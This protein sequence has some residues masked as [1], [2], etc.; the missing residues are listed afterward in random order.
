MSIRF[1]A[2]AR[3]HRVG[4]AR[5]PAPQHLSRCRRLPGPESIDEE[6]WDERVAREVRH[7]ELIEAS[8]DRAEAHARLGDFEHALDWLDRVAA[9]SGGL[10]AGY[11]RAAR[12]LGSG[13]G[14]ATPAGSGDWKHRLAR[15][16]ESAAGR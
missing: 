12:T 2:A 16:D 8:F 7:Q 1:F 14:V 4:S 11:R 5:P 13:R 3:R 9:L 10:P 6:G 15:S